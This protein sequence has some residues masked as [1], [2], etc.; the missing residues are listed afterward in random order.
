MHWVVGVVRQDESDSV[1]QAL[2]KAQG[3]GAMRDRLE[4][5][6]SEGMKTVASADSVD[7]A[8]QNVSSLSC[9]RETRANSYTVM[10]GQLRAAGSR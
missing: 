2:E 6:R 9:S 8:I 5:L 1:A 7:A 4:K 10:I 3:D